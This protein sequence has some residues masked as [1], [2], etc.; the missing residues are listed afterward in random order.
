[1][2]LDSRVGKLLAEFNTQG[3]WV[4]KTILKHKLASILQVCVRVC[5]RVRVCACAC[6]CA[7]GKQFLAGALP[8]SHLIGCLWHQGV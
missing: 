8:S 1:V 4:S 6:V 7:C 5:V 3:D 2:R